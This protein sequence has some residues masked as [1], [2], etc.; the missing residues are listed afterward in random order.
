MDLYKEAYLLGLRDGA[1]ALRLMAMACQ[2]EVHNDTAKIL[3]ALAASMHQTVLEMSQME[4]SKEK[5]SV[6]WN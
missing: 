5:D 6:T 1:K 2:D 4:K 3:N